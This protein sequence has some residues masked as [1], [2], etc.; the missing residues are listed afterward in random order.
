MNR[1]SL[2]TRRRRQRK[3][4]AASMDQTVVAR[5]CKAGGGTYDVE[6]RLVRLTDT[7]AWVE[8]PGDWQPTKF[9]IDIVR[10]MDCVFT[11]DLKGGY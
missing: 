11:D 7:F 5:R 4:L 3:L 1:P 10:P 2:Q 8:F 6:G 9:S